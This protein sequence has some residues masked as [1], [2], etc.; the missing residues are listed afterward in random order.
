MTRTMAI[1]AMA[2]TVNACITNRG[3][4]DEVTIFAATEAE[5]AESKLHTSNSTFNGKVVVEFR[6]AVKEKARQIEEEEED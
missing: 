2:Q 1:K 3:F 4:E 5:K 6:Q